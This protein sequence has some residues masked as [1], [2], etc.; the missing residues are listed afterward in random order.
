MTAAQRIGHDD[1]D[2][3]GHALDH[4]PGLAGADEEAPLER[5]QGLEEGKNDHDAG[6]PEREPGHL[7]RQ[8][9]EPF[10]VGPGERA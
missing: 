2:L 8:A 3:G 1:Q 10:E 7:R 5:G 4:R 9:R 6:R